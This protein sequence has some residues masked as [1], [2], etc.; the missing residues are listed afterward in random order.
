RG[1]TGSI[2]TSSW[3]PEYFFPPYA[4]RGEGDREAVEG[5]SHTRTVR[6]IPLHHF[7]VPLP[8][9]DGEE[10]ARLDRWV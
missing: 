3:R 6:R 5:K 7:V 4:K 2:G 1:T 9:C 10:R 8:I